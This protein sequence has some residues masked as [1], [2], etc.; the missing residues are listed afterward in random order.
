MWHPGPYV[1]QTCDT[2]YFDNLWWGA[3]DIT[4]VVPIPVGHSLCHLQPPATLQHVPASPEELI[5]YR[6]L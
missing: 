5:K 6:E 3:A 1:L 4:V 2:A